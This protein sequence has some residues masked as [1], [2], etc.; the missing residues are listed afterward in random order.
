MTGTLP[1][2]DGKGYSDWCVK[3]K[4]IMGFQEVHEIVKIGFKELSKN[5]DDGAKEEYREK[6][7]LDC[8]ARMLL[9]QCVSANV[10]QKISKAST[11][12]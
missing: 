3:M 5:A 4:A 8:K 6:K 2:F 1:V 10:F 7:R 12:K 9:H 11:T